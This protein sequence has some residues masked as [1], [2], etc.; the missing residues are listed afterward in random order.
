MSASNEQTP[1]KMISNG[2]ASSKTVA[3]SKTCGTVKHTLTAA[4]KKEKPKA[5]PVVKQGVIDCCHCKKQ[6]NKENHLFTFQCRFGLVFT[7]GVLGTKGCYRVWE[8]YLSANE[9]HFM[10]RQRDCE[11]IDVR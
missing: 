4:P 7:V 11:E 8:N 2:A 10:E 9:A 3:S 6:L 1:A 5:K